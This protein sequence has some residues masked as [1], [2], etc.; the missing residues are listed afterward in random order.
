MP[1]MGARGG[2][3]VRGFGRFSIRFPVVTGGTLTSDATYYYRTFTSNGTLS[4]TDGP[5]TVD[6]LALGGGGGG[7]TG[8]GRIAGSSAS[9]IGSALTGS[10][11]PVNETAGYA[12]GGNDE[13]GSP[14]GA[15]GTNVFSAIYGGGGG[16]GGTY[17]ESGQVAGGFGGTGGGGQGGTASGTESIRIG[18]PASANTGGGGGGS[19]TNQSGYWGKNGG[20]GAQVSNSNSQSFN[21]SYA[22]TIGAG[23]TGAAATGGPINAPASGAGGSGVVRIRYTR[24]S[25]GG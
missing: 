10:A 8:S 15:N 3:S 24:A 19:A 11:A 22:I 21:G 23:G 4:I 6:L 18:N 16:A 13:G 25:V 1:L 20:Q 2:G 14:N 9:T 12:R 7:G 5:L 17:Y